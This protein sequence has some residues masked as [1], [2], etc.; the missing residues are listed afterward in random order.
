MK[1]RTSVIILELLPIISAI[2]AY[3]ITFVIEKESILTLIVSAIAIV[4]AFNGYILYLLFRK[5][6]KE[7]TLVKVLGFLDIASSLAIIIFYIVI[8]HM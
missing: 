4:L 3:F 1:K 5:I 2:T 7:D 6:A 8:R